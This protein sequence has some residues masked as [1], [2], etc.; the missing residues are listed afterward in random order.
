VT[1]SKKQ[2][3]QLIPRASLTLIEKRHY[4]ESLTDHLVVAATM[5]IYATVAV[6]LFSS[7]FNLL[8][9]WPVMAGLRLSI[10]LGFASLLILIMAIQSNKAINR[11]KKQQ[12]ENKLKPKPPST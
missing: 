6:I 4:W 8:V 7:A 9:D 2:K 3:T 11:I 1:H 5:L 12:Q 10:M